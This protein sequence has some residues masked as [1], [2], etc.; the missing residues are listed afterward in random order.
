MLRLAILMDGYAAVRGRFF[1]PQQDHG[2]YLGFHLLRG[3]TA[4]GVIDHTSPAGA[5]G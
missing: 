3:I 4:L 1:A 2:R 5:L